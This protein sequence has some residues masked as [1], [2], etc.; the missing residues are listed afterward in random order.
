MSRTVSSGITIAGAA[1]LIGVSLQPTAARTESAQ[2]NATTNAPASPVSLLTADAHGA[3]FAV[4]GGKVRVDLWSDR[5]ARVRFSRGDTFVDSPVPTVIGAPAAVGWKQEQ[6]ADAYVLATGAMR[7]LVAKSS[8]E[9]TF[10]TPDGK[11]IGGETDIS[12]RR[13]ET[14][15]AA[16]GKIEQRFQATGDAF[17]GLGQH[18][19]GLLD[20]AGTIVRLQQANTDVGIPFLVSTAG[21][22]LLWNNASVTQVDVAMPQDRGQIVFRSEAGSETDYY[23][24]YGPRLHDVI[25]GYRALTGTPPMMARWTWGLWQ[26]KEHYATQDELLSVAARYRRM[27]VPLDA[28]VQDWQYWR[29]GQWGSHA[30]DPTRYPDPKAMLQR[31]HDEHVHSIV[32]VWA[33]FDLG[34]ANLAELSA[35]GAAFPKVYPNVYPAGKGRWYDPFSAKGRDIYW[36]QIARTLGQDGFDGYWLDASEA[37]LGGNWGEMRDVQT[38]AGPGA[39]V[40]N[41]YP[42][43]HTTAVYQGMHTDF[44]DKRPVILTRSAFAGQ[45]RNAAITWSGDIKGTWD[46]LA[47]QVPAA[48]NFSMSG[49]PYWAADIGGFFGGDPKDPAYAELFTRWLQFAVFNPMFRIHGTGKGKEVWEFAPDVQERLIRTIDLRYRLLPYIYSLSWGVTHDGDSMMRPLAMDFPGDVA[50]DKITDEYMFGR[51]FLV[52]PVVHSG[53]TSRHVLLPGDTAWYDFWT[54]DRIAGGRA[55][56]ASTPPDHIPLYVRAGSIVPLGPVVQYADEQPDAPLEI[57][58]YRGRDGHFRLYDDAGDG[59]GWRKGD[60]SVIDF[61]LDDHAGTL[62]IGARQGSYPGMAKRR[63]FRIVEVGPGQGAGLEDTGTTG[64]LVNYDGQPVTVPLR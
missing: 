38:A 18:Q 53:V 17:Y 22:G 9:V 44:P 6:T 42:L 33:R 36:R 28:V 59:P 47:A 32:S 16:Y 61:T 5:I 54:G 30:F 46:L 45:Q 21:W 12:H 37:E 52:S 26:S 23:F 62:T 13:T 35:A 19:N 51:A 39:L 60:H 25:A 64:T 8:G 3:T 24:I 11:P 14:A 20:N 50:L 41:A 15:P 31:L 7:V 56:S 27:G 2:A 58:V 10:Q 55:I 34:T 29:P 4:P 48:L 57:R 1:L 40:Y 63:R 49:I 43:L